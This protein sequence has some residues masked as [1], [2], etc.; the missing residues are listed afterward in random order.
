[1]GATG[2]FDYLITQLSHVIPSMRYNAARALGELG[3]TRATKILLEAARQDP[4]PAVREAARIALND[5]GIDP[6]TVGAD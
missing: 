6:A 4:S 5:L 1:M 2:K 3:D